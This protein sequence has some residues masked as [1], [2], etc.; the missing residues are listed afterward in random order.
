MDNLVLSIKCLRMREVSISLIIIRTAMSYT[1]QQ[2]AYHLRKM[3]T[4]FSRIDINKDGFISREDYE[5]MSQRMV[6]CSG[7]TK[8]REVVAHEY[9]MKIAD[10]QGL[11]PGVKIPIEDLAKVASQNLLSMTPEDR[12]A[13]GYDTYTQLFNTI[14]T[15]QD[16][17][18][19]VKEFKDYFYILA[20]ELSERDVLKSFIT[21]DTNKDGV[22]SKEEFVAAG[23]EFCTESTR[24]SCPML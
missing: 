10:L 22:I 13:S 7:M 17:Y 2:K 16:G 8:E 23:D 18:I 20:P 12:K 19:S 9:F 15:N 5:L 4:R 6:E 1:E 14:D 24:M 21:I 3:R 11:K